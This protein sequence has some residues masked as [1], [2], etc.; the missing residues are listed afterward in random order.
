MAPL[1]V[2]WVRLGIFFRVESAPVLSSRAAAS[3]CTVLTSGFSRRTAC[4]GLV[5]LI[6]LNIGLNAKILNSQVFAMFV[7]MAL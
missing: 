1:E 5:E 3:D 7:F 2:S 4:K 6:V